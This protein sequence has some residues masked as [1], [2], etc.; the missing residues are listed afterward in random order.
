MRIFPVVMGGYL[1]IQ[2][3]VSVVPD[4]NPAGI[5]S[6]MKDAK[7]QALE[8]RRDSE[9]LNELTQARAAKR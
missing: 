2:T 8:L 1:I 4:D 5:Q 3:D 7:A 6:L 9:E